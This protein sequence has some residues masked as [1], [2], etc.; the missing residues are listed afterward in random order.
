MCWSKVEEP[1]YA[2]QERR[3][4]DLAH[5]EETRAEQHVEEVVEERKEAREPA[6]V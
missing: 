3:V 5:I 2:E 6:R 1:R 4:D